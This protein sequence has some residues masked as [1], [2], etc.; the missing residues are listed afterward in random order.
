MSNITLLKSMKGK[1]IGT[2]F[3]I[4]SYDILSLVHEKLR[5]NR[6]LMFSRAI[7]SVIQCWLRGFKNM[8]ANTV[9]TDG[10]KLYSYDL[11]IG[12]TDNDG[13]K[14]I[15][16]YTTKGEFGYVSHTTSKHVNMARDV[17]KYCITKTMLITDD[18]H[19]GLAVAQDNL[20][21]PSSDQ[22]RDLAS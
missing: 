2:M 17:A 19:Q 3:D 21:S 4:L 8:Y 18:L 5:D 12:A 14:C 11:Q 20:S 13:D 9:K 7:R 6:K 15:K 16:D 22:V 1:D 10:K